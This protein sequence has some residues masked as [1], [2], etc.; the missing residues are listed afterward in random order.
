MLICKESQKCARIGFSIDHF[1]GYIFGEDENISFCGYILYQTIPIASQI[2]L[3][4]RRRK[5]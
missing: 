3:Y 2:N 1:D 4:K 5:S